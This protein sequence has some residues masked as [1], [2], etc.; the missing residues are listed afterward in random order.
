MVNEVGMLTVWLLAADSFNELV[1]FAKVVVSSEAPLISWASYDPV[2]EFRVYEP[3]AESKAYCHLRTIPVDEDGKSFPM[4]PKLVNIVMGIFVLYL[5][6]I[7]FCKPI[8]KEK[9][10]T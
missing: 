8:R 9:K 3:E 10:Q 7:L 2:V 6:V 4:E 5:C 1:P